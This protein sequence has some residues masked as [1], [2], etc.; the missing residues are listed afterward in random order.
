MT[1]C[2]A[3]CAPPWHTT[4]ANATTWQQD[5]PQLADSASRR[6]PRHRRHPQPCATATQQRP[7]LR[8]P[9]AQGRAGCRG[10]RIPLG[11]KARSFTV[12]ALALLAISDPFGALGLLAPH[13]LQPLQPWWGDSDPRRLL[14]L[15]GVLHGAALGPTC[16]LCAM[17]PLPSQQAAC[18][19]PSKTTSSTVLCSTRLA[20]RAVRKR[21][22]HLTDTSLVPGVGAHLLVVVIIGAQMHLQLASCLVLLSTSLHA[23]L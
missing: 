4:I 15:T 11:C 7:S 10:K 16:S 6:R 23:A 18:A 12:L 17:Q 8:K 3:Q 9:A 13:L 2:V 14:P 20:S 5:S 21:P 19:N 22:Q 1:R